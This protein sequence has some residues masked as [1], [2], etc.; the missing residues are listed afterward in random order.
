MVGTVSFLW[1]KRNM[2]NKGNHGHAFIR[3][4]LSYWKFWLFRRERYMKKTNLLLSL[5]G[6]RPQILLQDRLPLYPAM[7]KLREIS[8][9]T[10]PL[11]IPPMPGHITKLAFQNCSGSL[12]LG[13][14]TFPKSRENSSAVTADLPL[15]KT[16]NLSHICVCFCCCCHRHRWRWTSWGRCHVKPSFVMASSESTTYELSLP[17]C[18]TRACQNLCYRLHVQVQDRLQIPACLFNWHKLMLFLP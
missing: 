17:G 6:C 8:H 2:N 4:L 3:K 16:L 15:A 7:Q 18:R 11:Q 5:L 13:I 14:R 1:Q 9:N 12:H 10:P